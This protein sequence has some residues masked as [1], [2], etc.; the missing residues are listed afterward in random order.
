MARDLLAAPFLVAAAH[1]VERIHVVGRGIVLDARQPRD[2]I[3]DECRLV[4][5][6][7]GQRMRA[8]NGPVD[9]VD[10][11]VE[12]GR[13]VLFLERGEEVGHTLF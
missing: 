4:V 6:S 11:G 13:V 9:I 12:K 5:V 2:R 1:D 3:D 7:T 8:L 10:Y